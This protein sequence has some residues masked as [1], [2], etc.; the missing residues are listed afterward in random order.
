M[1]RLIFVILTTCLF[2]CGCT[3]EEDFVQYD[4]AVC[5]SDISE[6]C[7]YLNGFE[8]ENFEVME[9]EF[10]SEHL[11]IIIKALKTSSN[12][13]NSITLYSKNISEETAKQ[14][15]DFAKTKEIS[16]TF[17]MTDISD[18]ILHEYDKAF[19]ISTNYSHAAE[20]LALKVDNLWENNTIIDIDENKIFSFSVI[21]DNEKS[22]V[23]EH[24]YNCLVD[25]M[26]LYGIPMQINN[27]LTVADLDNED[28]LSSLRSN[29]EAFIVLADELIPYYEQYSPAGEGKELISLQEG[30]ENNVSDY[31]YVISCFID[32]KNYKLAAD[33]I[34]DGYNQKKF[35]LDS[36]TFPFINRTVYIPA[37]VN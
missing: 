23:D 6:M 13:L 15:I 21:N 18:E 17:A 11:D 37:C 12:G 16:V 7:I 3:K 31:P 8:N 32:Y 28:V 27:T 20:E 33:E 1:R 35:P 34:I 10:S 19:C 9:T 22:A 4:L 26:E 30:I 5:D 25:N 24:F 29:N 2:L 14:F 36:V